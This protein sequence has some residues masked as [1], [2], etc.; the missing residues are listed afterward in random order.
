M[1]P[2]KSRPTLLV[3]VSLLMLLVGS[4]AT[5]AVAA[6]LYTI[7]ATVVGQGEVTL[8]PYKPGGYAKNNIVKVTA[9]PDTGWT[10]QKWGGALSGSTNPATLRVAG[11]ATITATFVDS[12]S[13]GGTPRPA[14]PTSKMIVGYFAQW[15]IYQ[16]GY[17]VKNVDTSGAATAMNVMNYAFAA[18]D[19]NLNCA[20]LDTFADYGKAFSASESVDGVADTSSQP[21]KGNF[22]QILKLKAKYPKLRVLL[23]LGGWSQS[24]RFTTVAQPAK[25]AAFVKSCIDTFM[26]GNAAGVFDGFDIDWEY[27]GSCGL[28]CDFSE[29]DWDNFPA[30]LWEFR[31]QLD[32]FA[33]ESQATATTHYLLSVAAPAGAAKY[34]AMNLAAMHAPLDWINVMAYDF[35]GSWEPNGPTNHAAALRQSSCE[36]D[37]GDW[38]EKA[39]QAYLAEGVPPSKLLLGVPFYGHGWRGVVPANDGLC[40]TAAGLARGVYERGTNDYKVIDGQ[41]GQEFFDEVTATHWSFNGSEF[42]SFDDTDTMQ[43]KADYVNNLAQ[44]LRGMMFWELSG[45][46]TGA[47]D[48]GRLVRAM[49]SSLGPPAIP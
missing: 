39:I 17:L 28:T 6:P 43:W 7:T 1:N 8:D 29:D 49:R 32:T 12:S 36:P 31:N 38:G 22:N 2:R 33:K 45:D 26:R 16:R 30:L 24:Y 25:R 44:P 20:S 42:W 48:G 47:T 27:P 23:S 13:G 37:N 11:N 19:A 40:Q 14:L 3:A 4:L 5:V 9:I 41:K 10:F 46:T 15:A 35:H 18:P 21:L 34:N